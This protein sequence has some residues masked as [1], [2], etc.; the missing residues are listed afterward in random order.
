MTFPEL[1][2]SLRQERGLSMSDVARNCGIHKTAIQ[3][4]ESGVQLPKGKTLRLMCL[5]GLGLKDKS[6]EWNRL[7][8]AWLT[9]RTQSES[10]PNE[11]A[12]RLAL[13]Y[14]RNNEEAERF[15]AD[16]SKLD[17]ETFRQLAKAVKRP[18]VLSVLPTLNALYEAKA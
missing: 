10:A 16:I 2:R 17:S 15:F 8:A 9:D 14:L 11:L 6:D 4:I 18:L 3:K 1:F 5:R 13:T 12:G 7:N